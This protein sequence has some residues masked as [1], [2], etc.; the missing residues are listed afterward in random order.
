MAKK[1]DQLLKDSKSMQKEAEDL[2]NG[3][4]SFASNLKSG[5]VDEYNKIKA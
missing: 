5:V 3:I 4:Y 1:I 2:L